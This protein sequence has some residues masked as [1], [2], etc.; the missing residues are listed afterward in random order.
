MTILS[1]ETP[2]EYRGKEI[3]MELKEGKKIIRATQKKFLDNLEEG[4]IPVGRM[5]KDP[6]LTVSEWKEMRSVCGCLQWLG[7]QTRPD[8]ASTAS[9]SHRGAET[10]ISDLRRLHQTLQY[11]KNTADSGIT[12]PAIPFNRASVLVVFADSSWA[13]AAKHSSQFGTVLTMCPAQVTE[14]ITYGFIIDWKSGRSTRICRSTLAAE[15]CSADEGNDRSCYANMV[16]TELLYQTPAFKGEMKMAS[17]HC[18]DA[19]S[20]Y[21]ALVA[22]NLS[23]TEKRATMNIRSIQQNM[24]PAQIHWL[25]TNLM[26]ADGLTKHDIRLQDSLRK[27]CDAPTIQ[28]R[29]EKQPKKKNS[30]LEVAANS[31]VSANNKD[32]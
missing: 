2:G 22:E 26:V 20:L 6:K 8:V 19:K 30:K 5:Q 9:L 21:D 23:L 24:T 7:G 12:F 13:N 15:A 28:L 27:W 11:A 4:K 3:I 31:G 10:E 1:P 14:K 18:T 17:L 29:E 25:P 32:Q 16:I